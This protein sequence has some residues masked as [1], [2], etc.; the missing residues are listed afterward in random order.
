MNSGKW[1]VAFLFVL[2]VVGGVLMRIAALDE[3]N[4]TKAFYAEHGPYLTRLEGLQEHARGLMAHPEGKAEGLAAS[5][6]QLKGEIEALKPT[7]GRT[8]RTQ[9]LEEDYTKQV[10][11]WSKEFARLHRDN[12]E[13][14]PSFM[15][16]EITFGRLRAQVAPDFKH[17]FRLA[18][19]PGT[20][21]TPIPRRVI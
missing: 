9:L 7:T 10:S 15:D 5:A 11:M 18:P 13:A 21:P 8:I 3:W 12:P 1:V 17:T 20:M 4:R 6:D 14:S 2:V 19:A 16:L